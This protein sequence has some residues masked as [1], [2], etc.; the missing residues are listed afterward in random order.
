LLTTPASRAAGIEQGNH[1]LESIIADFTLFFS[2]KE[3]QS[4]KFI[5]P[6]KAKQKKNK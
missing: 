4:H 2:A 3:H 1:S 5:F 6:P